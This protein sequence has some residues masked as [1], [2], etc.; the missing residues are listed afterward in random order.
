MIVVRNILVA[1]DFTSASA[2][3]LDF[4]RLLADA[5]GASL[6]LLHVVGHA[7]EH[8]ERQAHLR[9]HA[10]ERLAALLD[11]TDRTARRAAVTCAVGTTAAEIV[12]YAGGHA[13]DLIVMGTHSHGPT[14][15]MLTG[16]VAQSV[17]EAA[18]CSVLAVKAG[19]AP[20]PGLT[21]PDPAAA[22]ASAR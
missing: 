8:P 3:A 16:S 18:P 12:N 7:M 20:G 1:I 21:L 4:G 14:F 5:T 13:I 10:C 19:P 6:H 11:E 9:Q 17:I 22:V 15:Q 2:H